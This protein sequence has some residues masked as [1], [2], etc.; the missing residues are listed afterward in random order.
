MSDSIFLVGDDGGLTEARGAAYG[1]EAELQELLASTR[2]CC[3]A[4]RL[5][6]TIRAS[7]C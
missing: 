5:T 1:A 3:R 7:G 2:I 6:G 4:R